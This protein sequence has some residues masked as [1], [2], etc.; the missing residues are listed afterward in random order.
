MIAGG[1]IGFTALVRETQV[2]S[3]WFS[4]LNKSLGAVEHERMWERDQQSPL[5]VGHTLCG[6]VHHEEVRSEGRRRT[7]TS[8]RSGEG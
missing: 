2:C 4:R 8:T 3:G 7:T 6:A 1:S 5:T